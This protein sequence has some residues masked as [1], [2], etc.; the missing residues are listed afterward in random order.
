MRFIPTFP[1]FNP[2]E[3][4]WLV[5]FLPTVI[6]VFLQKRILIPKFKAEVNNQPNEST[7]M[8]E[9]QQ[10]LPGQL[11]PLLVDVLDGHQVAL[12]ARKHDGGKEVSA[13][14]DEKDVC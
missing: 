4:S 13:C 12:R 5:F 8:L 6:C 2:Q 10:H 9:V 11:N 3:L 7:H 1:E 14:H